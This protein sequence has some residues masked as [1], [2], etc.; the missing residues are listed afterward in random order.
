MTMAAATRWVSISVTLVLAAADRVMSGTSDR[1]VR[2]TVVRV[3][4]DR[5]RDARRP[6]VRAITMP[7]TVQ[8]R[9]SWAN[10]STGMASPGAVSRETPA[11]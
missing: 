3:K 7:M 4:V 11:A 2:T 8:T 1:A 9:V 5:G 6:S 10:P